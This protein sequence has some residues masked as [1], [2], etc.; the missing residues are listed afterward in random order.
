MNK[1]Q[2]NTE[3]SHGTMRTQ[4]L[5]PCFLWTL[6][7]YAPQEHSKFTSRWM[8]CQASYLLAIGKDDDEFWQGE[9]AQE[10]LEELFDELDEISPEG[11]YFGAHP[12]DGSS[13]GW[14]EAQDPDLDLD[15][16]PEDG[17][18]SQQRTPLHHYCAEVRL[19]C[20]IAFVHLQARSLEHAHDQVSNQVGVL[21]V[22]RVDRRT[23][24]GLEMT[25]DS[26]T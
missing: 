17:P 10:M 7:Q 3:V 13:Y 6:K 20:G 19:E 1:P 26:G 18:I 11:C 5:L 12:G 2:P 14:W 22:R 15:L 4:D 9:R 8:D 23:M 21:E 16:D 25:H 24:D